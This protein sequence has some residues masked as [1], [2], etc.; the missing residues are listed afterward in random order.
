MSNIHNEELELTEQSQGAAHVYCVEDGEVV[1]MIALTHKGMPTQAQA[2]TERARRLIACWNALV[3]MST[4]DIE[5][6]A[7]KNKSQRLALEADE[8]AVADGCL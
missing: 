8:R 6:M 7:A 2:A 3:G 1:D 5:A 4:E